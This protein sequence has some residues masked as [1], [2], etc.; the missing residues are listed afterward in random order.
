MIRGPKRKKLGH[1]VFSTSKL[2]SGQQISFGRQFASGRKFALGLDT[3]VRP[4]ICVRPDVCVWPGKARL[5]SKA[6][7][8][9]KART[10]F[11]SRIR[12]MF[13][14]QHDFP[15]AN[16]LSTSKPTPR[17]QA[18]S[19]NTRSHSGRMST[20]EQAG[21]DGTP[22]KAL[23]ICLTCDHPSYDLVVARSIRPGSGV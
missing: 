9:S 14:R 22:P 4:V 13:H 6:R 15:P 3:R 1:F 2:R 21:P 8:A 12:T 18:R 10:R 19:P 5:G 23:N 16:A 17:Q 20:G 11:T 7:L